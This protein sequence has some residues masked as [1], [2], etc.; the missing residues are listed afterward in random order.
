MSKKIVDIINEEIKNLNNEGVGDKYLEKTHGIP[1]VD[2]QYDKIMKQQALGQQE[3][4]IYSE[5]DWKLIRNPKSLK[6]FEPS[7]RGVIDTQG[8]LYLENKPERIHHDILKILVGKGLLPNYV[9][10]KNWNA[11]LPNQIGFLTVQRYNN[12]AIAIGHSN[13]LIYDEQDFRKY[14][15]IYDEFMKKASAKNPDIGFET[16]LVSGKFIELKKASEI[17]KTN[18]VYEQ[19]KGN[20]Y[21]R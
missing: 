17:S 3:D 5:G 19:T 11:F 13:K 1:D 10:K 8:N 12:G 7:V 9:F 18:Q 20:H 16:K 14:Y 15:N 6:N 2:T 4:V 21:M